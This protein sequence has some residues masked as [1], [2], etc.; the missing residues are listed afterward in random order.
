MITPPG[1]PLSS[2]N[3]SKKAGL[4]PDHQLPSYF[5]IFHSPSIRPADSTQSTNKPLIV[6]PPAPTPIL[7][8]PT[9]FLA[10]ST[11]FPSLAISAKQLLDSTA[12]LLPRQTRCIVKAAF[13]SRLLCSLA[14]LS[15]L[16]F[17]SREVEVDAVFVDKFTRALR[18]PPSKMSSS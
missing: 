17:D 4:P 8:T 15:F 1:Y 16:T 5:S 6:P 10:L 12:P 3:T 14:I 7:Y 11:R 2:F 13:S 9:N 18:A